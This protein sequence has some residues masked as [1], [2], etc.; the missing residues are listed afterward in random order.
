MKNQL[1][2]YTVREDGKETYWTR[3]GVAFEN[4]KGFSVL[5]DA[6]PAPRDGR[7]SIVLLPPKEAAADPK[8]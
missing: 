1:I 8:R 2:A 3:I 7:F 6:M 4:K 5:L